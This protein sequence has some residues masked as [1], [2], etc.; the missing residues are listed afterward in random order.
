MDGAEARATQIAEEPP[1]EAAEPALVSFLAARDAACPSC[2]YNLKGVESARCPECGT[3]LELS[4]IRRSPLRG[5]GP[6]L[7]LA[8]AWLLLAGGM[9]T[10]RNAVQLMEQQQRQAQAANSAARMRAVLQAQLTALQN[11]VAKDPFEGFDNGIPGSERM[12]EFRLQAQRDMLDL[13]KQAVGAQ[14]ARIAPTAPATAPTLTGVWMSSPWM[15]KVSTIW[16]AGLTLL[17]GLGLMLLAVARWRRA[18]RDAVRALVTGACVLFAF[19][20]GWHIV[21][22]VNE[23]R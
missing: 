16:S 17:A 6:F 11:Q 18:G 10:A 12:R 9:N 13:Q 14:L 22:F 20:G 15:T 3:R 19:Y 23:M 4:L 1:M 21:L 5:W 7:L 2:G 8:F